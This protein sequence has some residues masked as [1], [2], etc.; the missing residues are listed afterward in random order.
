LFVRFSN[1]CREVTCVFEKMYLKLIFLV[2]VGIL[3]GMSEGNCFDG[4][5]PQA[6]SGTPCPMYERVCCK[7]PES[8]ELINNAFLSIGCED[9]DTCCNP[10]IT[11]ACVQDLQNLYCALLCSPDQEN[12]VL[13]DLETAEMERRICSTYADQIWMNC[14]AQTFLTDD[15]LCVAVGDFN[16]AQEYVESESSLTYVSQ[17][18]RCTIGIGDS[19]PSNTRKVI[20]GG[21]NVNPRDAM[22]LL[23]VLLLINVAYLLS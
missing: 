22:W 21:A 12:F 14:K 2:F 16:S 7:S 23:F 11:N 20:N 17:G 5:T 19:I 18:G 8:I 1:F 3:C 4:S 6:R 15:N 9:N 10:N 13:V